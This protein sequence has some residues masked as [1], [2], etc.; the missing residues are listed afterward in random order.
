MRGRTLSSKGGFNSGTT[1]SG[2]PQSDFLSNTVLESLRGDLV[3]YAQVCLVA[4]FMKGV[5]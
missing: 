2:H 3:L 1:G 4:S 5:L